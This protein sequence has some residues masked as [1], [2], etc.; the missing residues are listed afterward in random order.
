[1]KLMEGKK[2][3]I[4]GVS[5][6]IFLVFLTPEVSLMLLLSKFTKQVPKLHSHTLTKLWNQEY[7][8]WQKR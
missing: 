1:M 6:S 8:L 3:I 7:D 2:G 5:N 4:F